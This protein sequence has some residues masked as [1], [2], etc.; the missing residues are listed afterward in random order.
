MRLVDY[1]CVLGKSY[2]SKRHIA[3]LIDSGFLH[4]PEHQY[5]VLIINLFRMMFQNYMGLS[6]VQVAK[7]NLSYFQHLPQSYNYQQQVKNICIAIHMVSIQ[8]LNK[9]RSAQRPL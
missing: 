5:K 8:D 1:R 9:Y 3:H 6:S 7:E 2:S 4:H